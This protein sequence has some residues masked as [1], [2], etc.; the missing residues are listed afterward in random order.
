MIYNL[1]KKFLNKNKE[2]YYLN[3]Q[4]NKLNYINRQTDLRHILFVSD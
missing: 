2:F 4:E 3:R 1:K